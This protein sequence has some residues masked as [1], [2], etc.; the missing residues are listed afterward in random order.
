ITART[1]LESL[2]SFIVLVLF[3]LIMFSFFGL[4]LT[5]WVDRPLPLLGALGTLLLLCY[6][7][8]FLSSQIGRMFDPWN[9]FTGI[10]GRVM[11][12]TSGLWFTMGSLPPE[13][14]Q[15]VQYNPLAHIIEWIRD[16][17]IRDFRSDLFDPFYPIAFGTTLLFLGLFVDWLYRISGY[18]L[19]S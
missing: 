10:I 6:G 3:I 11:L 1:L 17:V 18:D 12:L 16:A 15:I 4:P 19:E 2:T 13:F 8:S 9:E 7:S 14:L 5:A